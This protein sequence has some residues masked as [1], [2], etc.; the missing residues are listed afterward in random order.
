MDVYLNDIL[1]AFQLKKCHRAGILFFLLW[2]EHEYFSIDNQNEIL[3]TITFLW[4]WKETE[5]HFPAWLNEATCDP[6]TRGD[7]LLFSYP[8]PLLRP[9]H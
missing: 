6:L 8:P 7:R 2:N 9:P 4:I 3:S 5:M 1:V